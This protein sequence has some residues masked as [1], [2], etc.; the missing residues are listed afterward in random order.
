MLL[1]F[2]RHLMLTLALVIPLSAVAQPQTHNL[3]DWIGKTPLVPKVKPRRGIYTSPELRPRLIALLG[4]KYY[5]RLVYDYYVMARIESIDGYLV[6]QM[7]RQHFCPSDASFMAVNLT[8]GDI[9]V[10]FWH[11]GDIEWFHTTGKAKDLPPNV[12][13]KPWWMNVAPDR[14]REVTRNAT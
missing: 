7:C 9:H 3:S 13:H 6:A 5:R 14:V 8:T 4:R 1:P 10:A 2:H 12:R 11:S